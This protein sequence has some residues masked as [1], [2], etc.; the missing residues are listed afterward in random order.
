[1][2]STRNPRQRVAHLLTYG[3]CLTYMMFILYYVLFWRVRGMI[4]VYSG[5]YYLQVTESNSCW[6]EREKKMCSFRHIFQD[7]NNPRR[8]SSTPALAVPTWSLLTSTPCPSGGRDGAP[9]FQAYIPA[10]LSK[11]LSQLF[12]QQFQRAVTLARLASHAHLQ[13]NRLDSDHLQ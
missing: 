3:K 7:A 4:S 2:E 1:M 6:L 8:V 11:S 13:T 12:L 5:F 10:H 9:P